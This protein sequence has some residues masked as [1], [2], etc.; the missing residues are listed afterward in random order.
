MHFSQ[1][2]IKIKSLAIM[3]LN[4]LLHCFEDFKDTLFCAT[5]EICFWKR[6]IIISV[7]SP[8]A[9]TVLIWSFFSACCSST[10]LDLNFPYSLKSLPFVVVYSKRLCM[11]VILLFRVFYSVKLPI[12]QI[13]F[14]SITLLALRNESNC[15]APPKNFMIPRNCMSPNL[16]DLIT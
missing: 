12:S 1:P 3:K 9:G 14:V 15:V 16:R 2:M 5:R 8:V 10:L 11:E 6:L 13:T 4:Q 7:N